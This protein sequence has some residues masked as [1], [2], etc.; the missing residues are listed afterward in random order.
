MGGAAALPQ[1]ESVGRLRAAGTKAL[2]TRQNRSALLADE[3]RL[4]FLDEAYRHMKAGHDPSHFRPA[5]SA[6]ATEAAEELQA[7]PG[8]RPSNR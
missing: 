4:R 6:A 1:R 3:A 8:A 7:P 5:G 2:R